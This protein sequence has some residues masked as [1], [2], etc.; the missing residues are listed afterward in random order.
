MR[1]GWGNS[2]EIFFTTL[3]TYGCALMGLASAARGDVFDDCLEYT[4]L[5]HRARCETWEGV[6]WL[7]CGPGWLLVPDALI[8]RDGVILYEGMRQGERHI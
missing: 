7:S 2:N 5:F 4:L 8:G 1:L 3:R 6:S